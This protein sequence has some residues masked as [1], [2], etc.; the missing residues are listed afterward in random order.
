MYE[1]SWPGTVAPLTVDGALDGMAT[2]ASTQNFYAKQKVTVS[3]AG[4][5]SLS[6]EVKRVTSAT[7]MYVGPPSPSMNTRAS[8]LGYTVALAAQVSA[9]E[10]PRSSIDPENIIRGAYADEPA[11]AFRVLAVDWLGNPVDFSPVSKCCPMDI[12]GGSASSV[13]AGY[14]DIDGG[15]AFSVYGGVPILDCGGS[16]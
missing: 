4:L 6:L 13:Y 15:D 14:M 12:D 2:V 11:V 3:A 7:E 5:P 16:I 8:L 10:Q 9:A 1:R